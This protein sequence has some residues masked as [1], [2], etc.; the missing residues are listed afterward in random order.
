MAK[1]VIIQRAVAA[2]NLDSFNRTVKHSVD[3]DNG[4]VF[5]LNTYSTI[6]GEDEVW[7]VENPTANSKNLWMAYSP[8]VVITEDATGQ[9]YV[10]LTK[11]PRAFTNIKNKV[12]D[13]FKLNSGDLIEMTG[14]GYTGI[15][16]SAFLN[17]DVN[18][19]LIPSATAS[20]T[21]AYLR[22]VKKSVLR[23]ND[24]SVG[25]GMIPTYIF[26]VVIA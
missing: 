18:L 22:K 11:D 24:G 8:E 9:H 26:E 19:K 14:E 15:E 7:T 3:V 4:D 1:N 23:L 10:G 6:D 16:T 25:G 21:G 12:F 20:A 17:V 2:S 13:A 5:V